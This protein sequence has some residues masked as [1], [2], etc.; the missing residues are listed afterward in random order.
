[1]VMYSKE[2]KVNLEEA[3]CPLCLDTHGEVVVKGK[4]II[5]NLP[6]EF[7]VIKCESCGLM[8][9]NPRPTL[10][11]IGFYYPDDYAPYLSTVIKMADESNKKKS[12][13]KFITRYMGA[14]NREIPSLPPGQ[15][16]E[17][18]CGSGDFLKT[19]QT[20]GW[21]VKGLEPSAT[22]ADNAKKQ[23]LDVDCG[24]LENMTLP[25]NHFD[26]VVGWMVLEHL[27]HPAN[28]LKKLHAALKPGGVLVLSVPDMGGLDF[29][30][31]KQYYYALHLPNHLFHFTQPT[32][33]KLLIH[34]G[35][36]PAKFFWHRNPKNFLV[37]L[38]YVASLY[39]LNG[40][41]KLLN[42]ILA[43]K[44]LKWLWPLLG[45]LLALCHQSGQ[46]TVWAYKG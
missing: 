26:L 5:N 34:N 22:A 3:S 4:D 35:F 24:N 15:L 23:G 30:F 39:K 40:V 28:G 37:S 25:E 46:M 7:V 32:L 1:M 27:H 29:R 18:G 11:T 10:D 38:V 6:G 42:A 9:T 19:M 43:R 17:I 41:E 36:K 8:R 21:T 16:L 2:M 14:N 33:K 12:L 31:F 13:K 45:W 44:R 20:K